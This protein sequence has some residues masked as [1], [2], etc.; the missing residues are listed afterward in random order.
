MPYSGQLALLIQR[1]LKT[2]HLYYLIALLIQRQLKTCPLC[3]KKYGLFRVT[4]LNLKNAPILTF[5]SD[6]DFLIFP[7]NPIFKY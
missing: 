6:C 2:F 4:R 7:L 3:L 1:Q 5:L